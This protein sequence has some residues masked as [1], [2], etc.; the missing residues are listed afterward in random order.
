MDHVSLPGKTQEMIGE[1]RS[2]IYK[3]SPRLF[4]LIKQV[5][6]QIPEGDLLMQGH[7]HVALDA[8]R[9]QKG[10]AQPPKIQTPSE[11]Y[12]IPDPLSFKRRNGLSGNGAYCGSGQNAVQS[13]EEKEPFP[14]L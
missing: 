6:R 8:H 13:Q 14:V 11:P 12:G 5:E 10:S 3:P 2:L 7:Y 1:I 4:S 9:F